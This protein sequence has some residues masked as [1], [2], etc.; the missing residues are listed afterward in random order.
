[1]I[2]FA[3]LSHL[4][5]V[6]SA[7][8]AANG[9]EVIGFDEDPE[10]V[11]RVNV[12]ALPV[13]EPGLPELLT[14]QRGRLRFTADPAALAFCHIVYVSI[15]V[16]TDIQ[17]RSDVPSV[18]HLLQ[19]V[20]AATEPGTV[21]VVL[22]QV[23]P[24]FCRDRRP[25]VETGGRLLY[26]QVETLIFGRAIERAVRPER[27]MVGCADPRH[28][29]PSAL[30]GY[31][32]AFGCPILL[33]RYESAELCKISINMFLVASLATTNMLAEVCEAVGAEWR[34]IEPAL[35]L[36]ARIGPQAYLKPGLGIAG[37]NLRRDLVTIKT[38]ASQYGCDAGL[39]DAWLTGSQYRR[40]WVL[41]ELHARVL[42]CQPDPVLAMW[43]LAYKENTDS[44]KNSAALSLLEALPG[45]RVRAYDPAVPQTAVA[46]CDVCR[47]ASP[48]DA[49]TAADALVIMTAWPEFGSVDWGHVRRALRRPVLVDP[50]GMADRASVDQL[51]FQYTRLGTGARTSTRC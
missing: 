25:Q 38:L 15:D 10:L 45:I 32:R 5:L 28:P 51:G 39:I 12:T 16:P 17:D 23:P 33:M 3:G 24:G 14:E 30:E 1:M 41:R 9:F 26:Y 36:D 29:L 8:A 46:G 27:F 34:E 7:A 40:D 6:S 37:G 48:L 19:V 18:E 50:W 42:S 49:C 22:S 43:G 47:V 13:V 2:G 4:G 21:I 11:A 31:L 35:R 44:T 20:T